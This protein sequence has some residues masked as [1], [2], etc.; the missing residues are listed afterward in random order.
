M[1]FLLTTSG[2]T[3]HLG[4]SS[5]QPLKNPAQTHGQS[6][7]WML[8][9][10]HFS[11]IDASG[12][13]LGESENE[14]VANI[15]W[16]NPEKKRQNTPN[17]NDMFNWLENQ[18]CMEQVWFEPITMSVGFIYALFHSWSSSHTLRGDR[19]WLEAEGI[20]ERDKK[21]N[22]TQKRLIKQHPIKIRNWNTMIYI[23]INKLYIYI[24][25]YESYGKLQHT[26][27]TNT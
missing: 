23:Y 19:F 4:T 6:S 3:K 20:L 15:S 10:G 18:F 13:P 24:Y 2:L 11:W 12:S 5:S 25:I 21:N 26:S 22:Q 1:L 16:T 14:S 27:E 7:F 8:T 17:Y 9:A